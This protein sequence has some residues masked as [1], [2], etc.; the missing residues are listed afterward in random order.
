MTQPHAPPRIGLT[1][2][3]E[4]ESAGPNPRAFVRLAYLR[5]VLEA[6]GWPTPLAPAPELI[7]QQLAAVDA[8]ILTGGDDPIMEDFGAPT[9]P[10]AT[11]LHPLRQRYELALLE[12]LDQA[13]DTPVLGVCLGMQLM[14]LRAGGR[15]D[16]HLP[17]R[18]PTASDHW[19]QSHAVAPAAGA[20]PWLCAGD[21]LS[22]HRQAITDPG[23]LV[24]CALAHDGLIEAVA[25]PARR[26]YAGVQWHPERTDGPLGPAVYAA[27]VRAARG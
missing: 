17:E 20:P 6:G 26:L 21:V 27:L 16:Q 12:A 5:A 3:I 19:E 24:A 8:V 23:R 18:L 14:A 2:D 1:M 15:L 9:H 22:R 7:A 25:D 11:P 13:P 10:K 4:P